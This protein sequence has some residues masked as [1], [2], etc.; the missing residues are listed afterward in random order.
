MRSAHLLHGIGRE[1]QGAVVAVAAALDDLEV[2]ALLG[3]D[4]AEP[5]SAAHDVGD[6]AGQFG[7]GEIADAFLHQADAGTARCGHARMP[8]DAAP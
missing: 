4:V 1:D 3:S 8:A 2:V 5:G 6:D 7:S